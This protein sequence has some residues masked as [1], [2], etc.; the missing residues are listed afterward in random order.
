VT[1]ISVL[2]ALAIGTVELLQVLAVE[3]SLTGAFWSWL[4]SLDFEAAGLAIVLIFLL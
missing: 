1:V 3:L 4:A 2:A